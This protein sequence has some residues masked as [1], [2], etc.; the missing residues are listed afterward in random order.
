MRCSRCSRRGAWRSP[1]SSTRIEQVSDLAQLDAGLAAAVSAEDT[2]TVLR[3]TP[4][5]PV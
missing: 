3:A 4:A 1:W 2:E 5:L